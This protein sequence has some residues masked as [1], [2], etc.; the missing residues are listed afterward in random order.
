M[1]SK[2]IQTFTGNDVYYK[3]IKDG[4]KTITETIHV[5]DSMP[6]RNVYNLEPSAIVHDPELDYTVDTSHDYPP[7]ITFNENVVTPD[8]TEITT[9]KYVLA[10]YGQN[11]ILTDGGNTEDNFSRIGNVQVNK[12]GIA[13]GFSTINCIRLLEAFNPDRKSVV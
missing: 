12:D 3:V 2:V 6:T 1:T 8:D 5:T 10:P 4:Y 11:Y 9:N 13:S 7:V